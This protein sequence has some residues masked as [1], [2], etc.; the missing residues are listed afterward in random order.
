MP[1]V[2]DRI[3][4]PSDATL[5]WYA[6]VGPLNTEVSVPVPPKTVSSP[7]PPMIVSSPRPL[8][9]TSSP[10]PPSIVNASA[11]IGSIVIVSALVPPVRV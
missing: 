5:N 3:R 4:R 8:V 10:E 11:L 7:E 1:S 2:P 6:A 9:I